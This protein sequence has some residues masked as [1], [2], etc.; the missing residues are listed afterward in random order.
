MKATD[1][2]HIVSVICAIFTAEFACAQNYPTRPIRFVVTGSGGS[3]DFA[4]RM[5]TQGISSGLGQQV[6]VDARG[7]ALPSIEIV[8]KAPS[9]GYTLLYFG[10]ALWLLPLLTVK[11]A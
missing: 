9:D 1:L 7:G 10:S 5:V 8:A 4:A 11:R 6:V 3:S 2:A